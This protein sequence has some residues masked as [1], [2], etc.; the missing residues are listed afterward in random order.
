MAEE[1]LKATEEAKIIEYRKNMDLEI[2]LENVKKYRNG[3]SLM[4]KGS[5][6]IKLPHTDPQMQILCEEVIK[7]KT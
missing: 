2:H 1:E 5:H 7:E 4:T 6:P 3:I